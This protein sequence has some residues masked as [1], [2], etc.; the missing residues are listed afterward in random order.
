MTFQYSITRKEE[1][2]NGQGIDL[3]VEQ[4]EKKDRKTYDCAAP[5][6]LGAPVSPSPILGAR[7]EN[8]RFPMRRFAVVSGRAML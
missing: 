7:A 8:E 4:K 5:P 3:S 2:A 1:R 6:C